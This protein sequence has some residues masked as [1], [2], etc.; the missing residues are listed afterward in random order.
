MFSIPKNEL[1]FVR[2]P[3]VPVYY[4]Y[5]LC[6]YM[7]LYVY[8]TSHPNCL[9]L[10]YPYHISKWILYVCVCVYL[11]YISVPSIQEASLL[12]PR[13]CSTARGN[14]PFW[15]GTLSQRGGDWKKM[16][17]QVSTNRNRDI[18]GISWGTNDHLIG[19]REHKQETILL[20]LKCRFPS[21]IFPL[22]QSSE[23][24]VSLGPEHKLTGWVKN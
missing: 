18:M 13:P 16:G 12:G 23:C 24:R 1:R 20:T 5:V 8:H 14:E 10:I 3:D 19:W 17:F 11:A 2:E 9:G 4:M 7:H 22:N 6:G 15:L 21:E